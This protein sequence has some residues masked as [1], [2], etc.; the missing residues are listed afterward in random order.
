MRPIRTVVTQVIWM[1]LIFAYCEAEAADKKEWVKLTDCQYVAQKYNDGD[2]FG[3]KCG[4]DEY[5]FRLYFVDA[6]ETNLRYAERTREQSEHFGVTL[7]ETM[8]A[9]VKAKEAVRDILQKPFVVW[10]RWATAQGEAGCCD[11]MDSSRLMGRGLRRFW[12]AWDWHGQRA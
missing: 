9:G 3:V 11:T 10:T 4:T 7:D 5:I 8:K 6:P 2:S 1:L 12:S